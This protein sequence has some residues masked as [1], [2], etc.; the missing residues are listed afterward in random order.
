MNCGSLSHARVQAAAHLQRREERAARSD[1]HLWRF[2]LARGWLDWLEHAATFE[3]DT[4]R[5]D[6]NHA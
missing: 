1:R 4:G 3:N 5:D 6:A 2:V